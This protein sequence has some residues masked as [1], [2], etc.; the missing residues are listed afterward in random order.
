[1]MKRFPVDPL[2][3]PSNQGCSPLIDLYETEKY[4]V[5]EAELPG[6]DPEEVVLQVVEHFLIVEGKC[7]P[8]QR[9]A[10]GVTGTFL[11]MERQA[12]TF[13]RILN[14]PIAVDITKGSATYRNGVVT[15]RFPKL[16]GKRITIPIE[17]K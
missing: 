8:S 2:M 7:P 16:K 1:M 15:I 9:E 6:V 5:F 10:S 11:C 14:I 13:R 17:Q 4:L 3:Q 12:R